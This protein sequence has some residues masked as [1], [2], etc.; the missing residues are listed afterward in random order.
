MFRETRASVGA[1][2]RRSGEVAGTASKEDADAE[3]LAPEQVERLVAEHE[4]VRLDTVH[5]GCGEGLGRAEIC[6][7]AAE[8]LPHVRGRQEKG[9]PPCQTNRV[10]TGAAVRRAS[11]SAHARAATKTRSQ[12]DSGILRGSARSSHS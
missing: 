4:E 12:A 8:N 2:R 1:P 10:S 3:P 9:S 11:R 5:D 6:A 7:P